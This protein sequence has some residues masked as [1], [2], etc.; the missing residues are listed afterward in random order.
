MNWYKKALFVTPNTRMDTMINLSVK[1]L[2]EIDKF[3]DNGTHERTAREI[4]LRILRENSSFI[5]MHGEGKI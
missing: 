2:L 5:R 3:I 1:E 4:L